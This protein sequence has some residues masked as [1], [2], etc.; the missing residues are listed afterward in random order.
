MD[1]RVDIALLCLFYVLIRTLHTQLRVIDEL[2]HAY[3][4]MRATDWD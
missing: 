1:V 4:A 3:D 2:A